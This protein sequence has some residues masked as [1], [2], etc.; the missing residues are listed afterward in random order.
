M[1]TSPAKNKSILSK[2]LQRF[3]GSKKRSHQALRRYLDLL[4]D[5]VNVYI[6][7]GIIR[8]IA[9]EGQTCKLSDI[10]L[11]FTGNASAIRDLPWS[12]GA[13][14]NKFGGMRFMLNQW[15]VDI[16]HAKSTWAID[17]GIKK[18]N[19]IESLL[20]TTISNWDAILF[21]WKDRKIICKD[22][23]FDDISSYY[24]DIVLDKNPNELGMCVR[25]LRCCA[26]KNYE[27]SIS[28]AVSAFLRNALNQYS[29]N[30]L[31]DYE[32]KSF[33][34]SYVPKI[35]DYLI[36]ETE[37]HRLNNEN[38]KINLYPTNALALEP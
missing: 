3:F 16:W 35:Y 2:R 1:K 21:N 23:Y 14:L 22:N 15:P 8:D 9:M 4:S 31:V 17:K 5:Q 26:S 30:E 37:P 38:S 7:G 29:I 28:P 20:D 10:D 25:L 24:L 11:V 18:F 34:D 27:V 13:K 36:N 19:S 6:F 12:Q 32:A 33:S